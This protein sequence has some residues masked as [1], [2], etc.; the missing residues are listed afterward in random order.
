MNFYARQ[1]SARQRTR[2]LV[3]LFALAVVAIVVFLNLLMLAV[4]AGTAEEGA[5]RGNYGGVMV[6][7][8][9]V[10]LAVIGLSSLY[11]TAALRGGGG[12]VARSLGGTRIDRS[13]GEPLQRRLFNVVE[14]MSIAAGVPVPEIYVLEQEAGINAFAAGHTAANAAV[15]VTRGAL[16]RL[17]RAELQGVI[18]HEF[19]H[20]L[21]GDMRLST[22]LMGLIFGLVV[23]ALIG[24]L[25]LRHAPR[26]S[27]RKRGG[28]VIV[29]VA[30]AVMILGHLGIFF[31]RLIQAAVS[32]QRERLADASAV[33]FTR[34]P[35][36]LRGA[37]VK[38][39]GFTAGS[40][41][42]ATDTEQVA[43]M[44]FAS[45]GWRLFA[46]H[47]PLIER[48]RALDPS[49]DPKEFTRVNLEPQSDVADADQ[50]VTSHAAPIAAIVETNVAGDAAPAA[51]AARV[52]NPGTS[53]IEA[54]RTLA[55]SLPSLTEHLDATDKAQ[56][57]L[58]ALVLDPDA[59]Q[60]RRQRAVIQEQ[61]G[62]A[63]VA[64]TAAAEGAVGRLAPMQRLP[65]LGRIFPSLRR[66]PREQRLR[67]LDTLQQLILLDGQVAIYEYA[68]ATLARVYL[69]DELE[70]V[71]RK[72]SLR[73]DEVLTEL[74]VV[75]STLARHG[76]ETDGA[77]REAYE[78][79][80]QHVLPEARPPYAP[81][82]NWPRPMDRALE[83]LDRLVPSAKEQLIAALVKTISHDQ[84]LSPAEA[85]LLR[86]ICA[87]V[88]CPLPPLQSQPAA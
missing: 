11:K 56:G 40:K 42:A 46:T 80:M 26:S 49:F 33:Q 29:L 22:R 88:H 21:N 20:I 7:T 66:L 74:Q 76:A 37:L 59:E 39:G 28:L 41:L 75:F 82:T 52:G 70:P 72:R 43:H 57:A 4:L 16:E 17:N 54:A 60:R 45:G 64:A 10:A 53:E 50:L 47:P 73:L 2:L 65:V 38:I 62:S 79:G 78:L 12:V 9:L 32:R 19:S 63:A 13:S 69:Q 35:Q 27:G 71:A 31:G 30:L 81:P 24:R 3:V 51:I 34:E 18:A 85:E 77:A 67:L 25:V 6:A 58:L 36:G 83:C 55:T 5:P 14:E 15:V 1:A 48:I 84:R 44:L 23:V 8:T 68:L 87:A 86:A 61:L